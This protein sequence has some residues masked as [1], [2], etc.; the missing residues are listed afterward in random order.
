MSDE[1]VA[2]T[3]HTVPSRLTSQRKG[4]PERCPV[5]PRLP[6]P[7]PASSA[8]AVCSSCRLVFLKLLIFLRR[9]YTHHPRPAQDEGY[10]LRV[11]E[12][13]GDGYD[14]SAGRGRVCSQRVVAFAQGEGKGQGERFPLSGDLS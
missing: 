8:P 10:P 2:F 3:S 5:T 4:D 7:H 12:E 1:I 11:N 13:E 6:L 9:P 14:Q